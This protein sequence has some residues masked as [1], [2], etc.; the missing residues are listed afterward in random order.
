MGTNGIFGKEGF[1]PKPPPVGVRSRKV[2]H[3]TNIDLVVDLDRYDFIF[4]EEFGGVGREGF[5]FGDDFLE[6]GTL[7]IEVITP[8]GW[9]KKTVFFKGRKWGSYKLRGFLDLSISGHL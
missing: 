3:E 1:Q 5:D 2:G 7:M 6:P 8:T 9:A 4:L